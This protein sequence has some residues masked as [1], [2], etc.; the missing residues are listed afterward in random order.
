MLC[1]NPAMSRFTRYNI[2]IQFVSNLPEVGGFLQ[3]IPI[4]TINKTDHHDIAEVLLKVE[5]NTIT[6]PSL[7]LY[8]DMRYAIIIFISASWHW[9]I[10]SS[11]VTKLVPLLKQELSTL[12]KHLSSP[13]LFSGDC[14]ALSLVFCVGFC[15]SLFSFCHFLLAIVLSVL[16]R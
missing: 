8:G 12:P 6:L 1:S 5:W 3:V 13:L 4:F 9:T 15:R 10:S 2:M 14:V 7:S 11:F 16:H